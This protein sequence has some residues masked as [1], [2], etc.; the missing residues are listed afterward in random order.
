MAGTLGENQE[1]LLPLEGFQGRLDG[2]HIRL[3]PPDPDDKAQPVEQ[4]P[5]HG[6]MTD[7]L[8]GHNPYLVLSVKGVDD[9]KGIGIMH[10]VGTDHRAPGRNIFLSVGLQWRAEGDNAENHLAD[11]IGKFVKGHRPNLSFA[12]V[13]RAARLSSRSIWEVSTTTASAAF[14]R[15]AAD[16]W[17]SA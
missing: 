6:V 12:R 5:H 3:P 13:I 4:P 17:L 16:R 15:G 8:L 11:N 10:M 1:L 2:P 14:R 9:V 7:L